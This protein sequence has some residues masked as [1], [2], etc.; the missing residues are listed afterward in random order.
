MAASMLEIGIVI[1][2][3]ASVL[4]VGISYVLAYGYQNK[5]NQKKGTR[6]MNGLEGTTVNLSCPPGQVINFDS[7]NSVISRGALFCSA[8]GS[9]ENGNP[10]SAGLDGFFQMGI[11]QSS[12]FFNPSTTVDLVGS[13]STSNLKGCAGKNSCTFVVPKKSDS[14]VQNSVLKGCNGV[15]AMVG[16][17]DCVNSST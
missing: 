6:G 11:G 7:Y 17:Y 1:I 15:I 13:S 4:I 12:H 10:P 9:G 8:S 14:L 16:T 3:A 5:I 2:L